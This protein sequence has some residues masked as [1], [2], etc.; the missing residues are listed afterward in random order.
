MNNSCFFTGHRIIPSAH[1]DILIKQTRYAVEHLITNH[2]VTD[3]ITGG[4]RGYDTLAAIQILRLR[5]QY[6]GLRLHLYLPCRDQSQRWRSSDKEVWHRIAE[7][8]DDVRYITDSKYVPGCMQ[9]RNKAMVNDALYGVAYLTH[10]RSGTHQTVVYAREAG[11]K[12]IILP[13]TGDRLD[14]SMQL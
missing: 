11:R 12:L 10:G 13:H 7:N 3:F 14:I 1:R 4:A 2:N 8:A 5:G 9:L 6:P